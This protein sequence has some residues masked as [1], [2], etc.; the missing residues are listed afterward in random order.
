MTDAEAEALILWPPAAKSWPTGKDPNAGK[1]WRQEKEGVTEDKMVGWHH[2]LNGHE[3][4][5][6]PGDSEGQGSLACCKPWGCKESDTTEWLNNHGNL[7]TQRH[8]LRFWYTISRC[9]KSTGERE[10][11][12]RRKK[13][14]RKGERED[15]LRHSSMICLLHLSVIF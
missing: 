12:E 14:G 3:F 5:Q 10:K 6:T 8:V 1:D 15:K 2:W 11:V 13:K 4:E 7:T 9:A